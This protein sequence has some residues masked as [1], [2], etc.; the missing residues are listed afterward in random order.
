MARYLARALGLSLIPGLLAAAS[1]PA[2]AESVIR[3]VPHADLK[4]LDPSQ[5]AATITL[6]HGLS[7]FDMLFAFDEKLNVKPQM[8]ESFALSPDKLVYT[9]TLRPGLRFQDGTPVTSRDVIPS[10]ERWMK[11]DAVGTKLASFL[12]AMAPVD[13]RSFKLTLKEPYG[14][15]E[16]SFANASGSPAFVFRE[17]EARSDPAVPFTET[18]GSGPFRFVKSAWM[19]GSTVVYEKNPD[20]VPRSD[21]PDGLAG[22]KIVKV[23][24]IEYK[25][26]PD[27]STAA[28]ALNA[29][30]VDLIDQ[31]ALDLVPLVEKNPNVTVEVIT[32]IPAVAV[33]RPN[34]LQ[35]PFNNAKARAALSAM[36]QQTD[37]MQAAIGDKKWWSTCFSY[38]VCGMPYG[39]EAGSEE[40]RKPDMA[41][42]KQL[43]GES[44]YKGGKAVIVSTDEIPA[45]G[46]MARVAVDKLK[47]LGVNVDLQMSDWGG[48][49]TKR[50]NR[51]PV[52]QGGW[53][54]FAVS[55]NGVSMAHPLSNI[56][57]NTNC[58][59]TNWLGWPCD[60]EASKILDR[61]IRS[62]DDAEK[63]QIAE[64]LH[65]RL[66]QVQPLALAG[67]YSQ[68]TFYRK[69]LDG[70]LKAAVL[71]FW[72]ISKKG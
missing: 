57:V 70:V 50:L 15:V 25:I 72:N 26:L 65:R 18:I 69:S 33:L 7:I 49:I 46:A 62:T 23:D 6:M 44:G 30:E 13:D 31:P 28:A 63:K 32:P 52:E 11:K 12:A 59:G 27:A 55:W 60:E 10:L 3:V 20:Y 43:L 34:H 9:M 1:A 21:A 41:K 66:W 61:F 40:Y 54:L 19:P 22:G 5:T 2:L 64:S 35:P 29:G 67:Q 14:L 39:T 16:W 38:F 68:P 36:M 48:V 8:I 24:R 71:V 47:Q 45:Q 51:G 37:F 42:A 56:A 53:S 17:K 58:A 4:V